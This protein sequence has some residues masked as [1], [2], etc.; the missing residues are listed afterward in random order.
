MKGLF[1]TGIDTNVGKTICAAVLMSALRRRG[2]P[3]CYWKPIQTGGADIDNQRVAELGKPHSMIPTWQTFA[4][5]LSPDQAAKREARA[6]PQLKDFL[7]LLKQQQQASGPLVIEGAGGKSDFVCNGA[8][9][10][11]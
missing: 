6:A 5:P 11:D 9:A 8:K 2:E 7:P 1:V 3:V 10:S 4:A